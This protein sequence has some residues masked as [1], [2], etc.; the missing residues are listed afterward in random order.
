[1]HRRT[2]LKLTAATSLG[3]G[4][5][6]LLSCASGI[7]KESAIPEKTVVY[8]SGVNGYHTYRIP[9][10]VVTQKGTVLAF[11]EGRKN[12]S[13]DHGNIDLLVQ[14]SEDGGRHWAAQQV[15]YEEGGTEP[16]TIGNPCPVIDDA[17]G[18]IW[19]PFTRNNTDVLVTRSTDDGKSWST[20]VTITGEVKPPHWSWYATGPG[21]GIQLRRGSRKGRLVIPCDHREPVNGVPTKFSH[22][23]YSDDHGDHW[24][25]GGSVA[26]LTDECQIA[27]LSDGR[28]M[29]NMRNY[30]G[31]EGG[32]PAH[33]KQRAIANS[34]DAGQSWGPLVF[35][36]TLIEPVCQASLLRYSWPG[37]HN[38]NRL[39]FSNPASRTDRENLTVRL[40]LDEGV[41]W[42]EQR[43]L[44]TGPAA[45]SC[46]TKLPDGTVGCLYEAGDDNPYERIV[47]AR[48]SLAWLQ[49]DAGGNTPSAE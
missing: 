23:I 36:P 8:R 24:Q 17:T 10:V 5:S 43:V 35:D 11:C 3:L 44:Q 34:Q 1:M 29:I 14:R 31:R 7:R 42:P 2:F 27:E 40:S 20:P 25:A 28:L 19:L 18:V 26:P 46:L 22:V 41:S 30:Q 38:R 21:I 16:V 33:G 47:F 49:S 32:D 15:V 37:I 45:Y 13:R 9:A 6:S 48:F 12:N 39:L 4:S